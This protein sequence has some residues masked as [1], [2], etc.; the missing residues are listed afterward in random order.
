LIPTWGS[1]LNQSI[2]SQD[3]TRDYRDLKLRLETAEVSR[4]RIL[5]LLERAEKVEDVIKLE[6]EL[7][8]LTELIEQLRGAGR[9]LSEQIAYSTVE[10]LFKLP[11]VY[12]ASGRADVRSP[13]AWIN[14]VGVE[15]VTDEFNSVSSNAP[16]LASSVALILPGGIAIQ[17][18][19]GFLVIKQQRDELK[20]ITPDESKLWIRRFAAP[21]KATLGFW[22]QALKKH[23]V[24]HRGYKLLDEQPVKDKQGVAG[25]QLRFEAMSQ[26][27]PHHYLISLYV[28]EGS[29]WSSVNSIH[30]VEFVATRQ[31]FGKYVAAVQS[32][33]MRSG[34]RR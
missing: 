9:A 28:V 32:A 16:S 5:A 27:R 4:R 6:E 21:R 15:Q 11:S 25:V 29:F 34:W 7:R 24:D 23:F 33:T 19:E 26:G 1:I 18:P 13:F 20:A 30:V 8:K 12:A 14:R 2:K 3:M 22:T 31:S 10:V 17:P